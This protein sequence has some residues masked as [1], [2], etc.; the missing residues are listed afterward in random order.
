MRVSLAR[1][2]LYL[3]TSKKLADGSSPIMLICSFNGKK[4]ISTHYSCV[5]KYWDKRNECVKKSY[6]NA[7]SII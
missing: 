4:E 7:V 6:P 1:I 5:P 3:K 2:R